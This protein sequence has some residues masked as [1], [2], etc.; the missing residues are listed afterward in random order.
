M[1]ACSPRGLD[2]STPTLSTWDSLPPLPSPS[3]VLLMSLSPL[4]IQD[5][6]SL[7]TRSL[8]L[9]L[10]R[11]RYLFS[12]VHHVF[13][14]QAAGKGCGARIQSGFAQMTQLAQSTSGRQT[15]AAMFSLCASLSLSLLLLIARRPIP[16]Y[17][18]FSLCSDCMGRGYSSSPDRSF[19]LQV[20]FLTKRCSIILIRLTTVPPF[21]SFRPLLRWLV[22]SF[23]TGIPLPGWPVN[24]TCD[25]VLKH[26]GPAT[27]YS[28]EL[29]PG[30]DAQA[31][32]ASIGVFYNGTGLYKCFDINKYS[33]PCV[34]FAFSPSLSSFS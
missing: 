8:R 2:S 6:E 24:K 21:F 20:A 1:A 32:A 23:V 28:H 11:T 25:I 33:S 13:I 5:L 3:K 29:M 18:E 15:L 31:L 14:V 26:A 7:P 10:P 4:S 9:P 17:G 19:M 12:V 22:C 34:P 16:P 30:S 27:S